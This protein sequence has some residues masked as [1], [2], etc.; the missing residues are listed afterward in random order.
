MSTATDRQELTAELAA[1]ALALAG[2][3]WRVFPVQP[4]RKVPAVRSD[5]EGRATTDPDRIIRCW[6]AGCW[7][8]GVAAGPSGL[9]V[10]DLDMPKP[11]EEPPVEWALLGITCG[12]DV[13]AELAARAGQ[14]I[15]ATFTVTTPSG[16]RHLYFTA[17]A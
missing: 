3:G 14:P 6:A 15:P 4:G 5:W 9:V 8:M 10:V 11:G 12:A 17:P 2:R 16:G 1:A 7:N 13:F